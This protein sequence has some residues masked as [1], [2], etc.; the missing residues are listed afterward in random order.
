MT[1]GAYN[2]IVVSN[3]FQPIKVFKSELDCVTEIYH[4]I[5]LCCR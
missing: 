3:Q 4:T 2:F 1:Q 5:Y